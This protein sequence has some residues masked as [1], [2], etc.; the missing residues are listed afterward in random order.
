MSQINVNTIKDKSGLGAPSFPNGV[1]ATGIITA[2]SFSGDGGNLTGID[3]SSLRVG[4]TTKVQATSTGLVI[5]GIATA[6]NFKTGS[7]NVHSVGVE[8]AGINVLG[9]DTPIGTGSTIYDNGNASFNGN[10]TS[11]GNI[12]AAGNVTAAGNINANG[13]IVGD[14]S[15]NITGI[16]AITASGNISA[17]D[18]TFT[19]NV[20]VGGTLTYEDVSNI[21]SVGLITA[22]GGVR[23]TSGGMVVAGISTFSGALDI[24]AGVN[25]SGLGDFAASTFNNIRAAWSGD[26][27]IDT[28]SGNLTLD[29]AGGTVVVDDNLTVNGATTLG[30]SSANN[31]TYINSTTA[32]H[33]NANT[34]VVGHGSGNYAGMTFQCAAAYSGG[35]YFT[36]T[37]NGQE[38]GIAYYHNGD[39]LRFYAGSTQY[40]SVDSSAITA[41]NSVPFVGN[42]TGNVTGNTS[43]SSGSCTGN[44][45]TATTLQNARTIAGVSFNGSANISLNNNAITNGAGYITSSGISGG[46]SYGNASNLNSGTLPDARFP[47]TLPAISGANLTNVNATTLDSIDSA[48]FARSDIEETI[49][50]K[51]EFTSSGSWPLKINGTDD[52]KIKLSGS[53][54]PKIQFQEGTTDKAQILW[55]SGGYLRL[56]N[57]EDGSILKIQDDIVFSSDDGSN[58]YKVWH[59]GNDG[60]G[61]GLDADLLDGISGGS[62][63]RSDAA[64][65]ASGR[66][67]FS[68]NATSNHDDMA[69]TTGS[70]GCIEVYNQGSGNDAFMAFHTGSDYA[71]YFGLDADTNNL[72]VGGWSMGANK[73]K[74][75][76][77]GNDGSGST[78]DADLLDGIDS[79]SFLRSDANDSASGSYNFTNSYNAFGNSTGSVS[80][81]GSWNAR[82]NL[83]G[84][85]HAR[86]DVQSVS[87]GIITTMSAHTGHTK[88]QLGTRSNHGVSFIANGNER[89]VL[90]TGGAFSVT[91]T[92]SDSKG[93]LRS[94]PLQSNSGSHTLA[95]SSAGKVLY[96]DGNTNVNN[97]VFSAGDAVTIVNNSGSDQTITQGS[98][99]TLYNTGDA[100][101]GNRTLASRGMATIWFASASVA[102]ISG[103]GLS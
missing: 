76:H 56:Q 22:R 70:M 31:T 1:N 16:N 48:S 25:I 74:I 54:N 39:Q 96:T 66:I 97:S 8:A 53:S 83:A 57:Q 34:L 11:D 18:A 13:N 58:F 43:G 100:S 72:S 40:M 52:G 15:T 77:A 101:T 33:S 68:G 42:L 89:A 95:A 12:T 84:S 28:S 24:N 29:S 99:L 88:G 41:V 62:Y 92:I 102:Y 5:T 3:A 9:A 75:W 85:S 20:S 86:F 90:S 47:A 19:G 37:D 26:G 21:D 73:Y 7:T 32:A 46:F 103:A 67:T 87:D 23:V 79:S 64:D 63:L 45:L 49:T 50:G 30:S 71:L 59:A 10:V 98:G 55:H 17:V 60:V 35:I 94:I 91:D 69:T 65:T 51:F 81:N 78:L 44:A 61:S 4:G 82:L 36:D 27:E 2:T 80:N 6:S 14:N 38:G 93:N